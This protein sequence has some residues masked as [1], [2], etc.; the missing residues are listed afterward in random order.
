MSE[1]L[2]SRREKNIARV[3]KY[4]NDR[5]DKISG[6]IVKSD[7]STIR[8]AEEALSWL[9]ESLPPQNDTECKNSLKNIVVKPSWNN[10]CKEACENTSGDIGL[11]SLLSKE[12]ID[13]K[14]KALSIWRQEYNQIHELDQHDVIMCVG[15]GILAAMMDQFLI[16]SP[17]KT[18]DGLRGKVLA[19]WVRKSFDKAFPEDEMKKLARSEISKVPYD[20]PNNKDTQV[21]VEGL[22]AYYHRMLSLGHD[23]LLGLFF[24]VSDII[25]GKM[26]TIDKSGSFVSQTVSAFADRKETDVFMAI[27]RQVRHF[28]SDV[29]T[30]MGLPAPL[31]GLF[32]LLQFGSITEEKQ[33][34]AEIV[35]GMYYQGYDFIHFCTLSASTM[36]IEVIVRSGYALKRIMEGNSI[37]DSIPFS[38]DHSI[39]PKL[40]TMLFISHS[41][42][43]ALN[44]GKVILTK[45][46]MNINYPEW[47]AFAKNAYKQLKWNLI[48][49]PAARDAY[50]RGIIDERL[51]KTLKNIDQAYDELLKNNI[52]VTE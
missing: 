42:A 2:M 29:T 49:K 34:I 16:G 9:G 5:I 14:R 31:M 6:L 28:K 37:R 20:V 10:L 36:L 24:G 32:N 50:V 46:P 19:N 4:H 47:I 51:Q 23:P 13:I 35:Q 22:S 26:T 8:M 40:A 11:E 17:K 43:A 15:A 41:V 33:T 44:A 39:H 30:S 27:L 38:K 25:S 52:V 3:I 12:D 21:Y 18:P 1:F 7:D 48:Q 45:D